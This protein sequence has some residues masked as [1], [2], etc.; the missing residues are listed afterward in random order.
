MEVTGKPMGGDM[1]ERKI[2]LPLL[3]VLDN[4]SE[5]ERERLIALLSDVRNAPGNV[6]HLCR[7]VRQGGGIEYARRCM[8]D[9]KERAIAFLEGY[10]DS[11]V[12][13]A[14]HRFA[15]YVLSRD[16]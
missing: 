14:L 15:D 10:P 13:R 1:R 6:D 2:T 7:A 9:Y 12:L 4:S 8:A 3:Y 5:K 16:K 11:D